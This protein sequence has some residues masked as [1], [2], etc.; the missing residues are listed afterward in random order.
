VF[1]IAWPGES[2]EALY[3]RYRRAMQRAGILGE[4][5]RRRHFIPNHERRRARRQ[6]ALRRQKRVA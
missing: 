4:A 1:V 5:R 6:Q 3:S 2:F